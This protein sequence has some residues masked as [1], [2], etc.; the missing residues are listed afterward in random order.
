MSLRPAILT[1]SAAAGLATAYAPAMALATPVTADGV[2]LGAARL[3]PTTTPRDDDHLRRQHRGKDGRHHAGRHRERER[4]DDE[5]GAGEDDDRP[6][7]RPAPTSPTTP[8]PTV[9]SPGTYLGSATDPGYG[10][11]QVQVTVTG[12]KLT[13]VKAVRYPTGLRRSATI[14]ARAIPKLQAS[15]L[16]AQSTSFAGVS[17]ATYTTSGFKTSLQSA[18]QKAG[19]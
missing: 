10:Q 3:G 18:L 6:P 8:A 11:I 19:K 14:N 1:V 12:S 16:A 2:V 13:A 5:G 9:L 7:A 17:G 4:G 15:A